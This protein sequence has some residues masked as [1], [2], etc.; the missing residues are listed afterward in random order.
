MPAAKIGC[1]QTFF[2]ARNNFFWRFVACQHVGVG[3]ARHWR[4]GVAFTAAVTRRFDTRQAR[5]E[6]ILDVT[7]QN[8]VFNQH[9]ALA[10]VAFIVN[11]E[12]AAPVGN[13]AVVQHRHA[14]G[15]H[16]FADAA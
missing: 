4:V 5:I 2:D 15:R 8:T 13:G 6:R 7:L 3:H 9:V 10:D 16:A 12:G 11:I 1:V 14:F